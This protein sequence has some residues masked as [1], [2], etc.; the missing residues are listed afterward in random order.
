M[1]K[2]VEENA[3]FREAL[4]QPQI[5]IPYAALLFA[6]AIAYPRLDVPFYLS[7]LDVL[8]EAARPHLAPL[9]A[10]GKPLTE[11]VD[12]LS[13]FLFSAH[14]FHGNRDHYSDPRNS[15]L[16]C[17]LDRKTG[18]PVSLSLV[19]IAIARRL[20]LN[21]YGIGLPGHFIAGVEADGQHVYV[22]A[23]NAGL[24]LSPADCARLV[25]ESSPSRL[26][27]QPGWLAPIR[28]RDFIARM[29]TNLCHAYI[30]SE[31]WRSAIR[32]IQHLLIIQPG[33]SFHLRDLGYLYLYNGSLRLSA[34][35]LEAYLQRAPDAPDFDKVRSSLEIVTGRMALWN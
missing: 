5:N 22:D 27:F 12:A 19:Y 20:G 9:A 15:F 13:D 17:V 1:D 30:Q 24:R 6:R 33:F 25:R 16:N 8:A 32:A 7:R 35:Y 34:Q 2:P 3:D 4:S 29:L 21:A 14:D 18:I 23:F 10:Q 11:R 28:P 31:N 26:P